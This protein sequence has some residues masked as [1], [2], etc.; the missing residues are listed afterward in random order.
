MS[1][2]YRLH[3]D[4]SRGESGGSLS[5]FFLDAGIMGMLEGHGYE[6]MDM[7]SPFIGA[8]ID[9]RY[10]ELTD[11]AVTTVFTKFKDL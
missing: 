8:I 2:G 4:Y 5:G 1:T 6:L 10:G 9:T 7:I 3:V 11:V